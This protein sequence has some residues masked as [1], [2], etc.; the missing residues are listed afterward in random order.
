MAAVKK[1]RGHSTEIEE[2]LETIDDI[3]PKLSN[4]SI[5]NQ[6]LD[7]LNY[8]GFKKLLQKCQRKVILVN[9]ETPADEAK[10]CVSEVKVQLSKDGLIVLTEV[11]I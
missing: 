7:A 10:V 9:S 11:S 8:N 1:R 6:L 2:V 4:S 5:A 3:V